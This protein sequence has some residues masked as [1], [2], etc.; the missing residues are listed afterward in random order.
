M[1][2]RRNIMYSKYLVNN[3]WLAFFPI[4]TKSSRPTQT[5]VTWKTNLNNQ[6]R[7]SNGKNYE[8]PIKQFKTSTKSKDYTTPEKSRHDDTLTMHTVDNMS[9]L[10]RSIMNTETNINTRDHSPYNRPSDVEH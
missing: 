3:I 2:F 1:I 6:E 10:K 9:T 5:G 7:E 4:I 8:N